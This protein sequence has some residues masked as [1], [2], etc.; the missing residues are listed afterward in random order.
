[1]I[2]ALNDP[3][4]KD[5]REQDRGRYHI[6]V[7]DTIDSRYWRFFM[8]QLKHRADS[9]LKKTAEQKITSDACLSYRH[10]I[11]NQIATGGKPE[12]RQEAIVRIDKHG[13]SIVDQEE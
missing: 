11:R 6:D 9:L 10:R 5:I 1:M 7:S 3:E 13:M 4:H 2:I 12:S 8:T